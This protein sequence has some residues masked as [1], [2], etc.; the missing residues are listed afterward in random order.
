MDKNKL[1]KISTSQLIK[2]VLILTAMFL[3]H[4]ALKI[5]DIKLDINPFVLTGILATVFFIFLYLVKKSIKHPVIPYLLLQLIIFWVFFGKKL[6]SPAGLD[7]KPHVAVFLLAILTAG[8]FLFTKFRELWAYTPFRYIFGFFIVSTIYAFFYK[9][10]FRSSSYIDLWIQNNMGLRF[11]AL[12]SGAE[13]ISREFG[14]SETKFLVYMTGIAPLVG[15]LTG[16]MSLWNVPEGLDLKDKLYKLIGLLSAGILGYHILL[17]VSVLIGTSSVM[18]IDNRLFIDGGFAGGYFEALFLMVMIAFYY[19]VTRNFNNFRYYKP[20]KSVILINILILSFII[21][22][23]IKKGTIISLG[24]ALLAGIAAAAVVNKR[25]NEGLTGGLFA[26][27]SESSKDNKS[28]LPALFFAP[29]LLFVPV[30]LSGSGGFENLVYNIQERFTS[31]DTLDIRMINWDMYMTQWWNN[32][33]FYKVLFGFGIDKSR[34]MTFFL[35]AMHPVGT[36]QQPHIH[37]I[38]LE[39]FYNY[40]LMAFLFFLPLILILIS[41]IKAAFSGTNQDGAKIFNILSIGVIVFFFMY[42]MAE[43]PSMIAIILIFTLLGFLESVR[44]AFSHK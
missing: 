41:N 9:T 39:M 28:V 18:F 11:N 25:S 8:Y 19:V 5:L 29:V 40:G 1:T 22:L 31:N 36:Y 13:V 42:Y 37:N 27:K 12:M 14:S 33:D 38:Y 44:R 7:F 2:I 3:P 16:L 30:F 35:T 20:I 21:L 43:S 23:G 24:I 4:L 17:A 34:E 10:D 6:L 15:F 32:L 26:Q